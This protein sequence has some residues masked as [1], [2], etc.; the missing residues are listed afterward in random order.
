M[1]LEA[2]KV[3]ILQLLGGLQ[4][5]YQVITL[6]MC[7]REKKH[8]IESL[9]AKP[10]LPRRWAWQSHKYK[11]QKLHHKEDRTSSVKPLPRPKKKQSLKE[12]N[13]ENL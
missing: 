3:P 11:P 9:K 7:S 13:L 6:H 12:L 10:E 1:R 4:F 2:S 5:F 8:K